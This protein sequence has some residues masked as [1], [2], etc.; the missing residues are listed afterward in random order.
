M[1]LFLF[2][3]VFNNFF[4]SPAHNEFA[5][6]R[7]ALVIPIGAPVT[8][9]KDPIETPP[10]VTDKMKDLSK[11]SKKEIYLLSFSLINSLSLI[12]TIKYSSISLI[13]FSLNC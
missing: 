12:S 5:R 4:T 11:E 9:V 10:I 2:L 6:L 3:V 8:V 13:L 7:L 1:L